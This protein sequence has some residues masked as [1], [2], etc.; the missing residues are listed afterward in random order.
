MTKSDLSLRIEKA[1]KEVR[2]Q[3]PKPRPMGENWNPRKRRDEYKEETLL[4]ISIV[5][6]KYQ[7]PSL[8]IEKIIFRL[9]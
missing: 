3:M 4:I 7:V 5:A 2:K 8:T 1:C 6:E 9:I